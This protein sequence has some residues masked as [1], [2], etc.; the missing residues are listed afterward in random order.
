VSAGT[1]G[2]ELVESIALAYGHIAFSYRP[3]D[4]KGALGGEVKFDWNVRTGEVP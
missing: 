3:Q 2:D 1:G 4:S